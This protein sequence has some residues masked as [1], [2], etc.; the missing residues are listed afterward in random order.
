MIE[1]LGTLRTDGS[2]KGRFENEAFTLF[3]IG[4]FGPES[5]V[6]GQNGATVQKV[7]NWWPEKVQKLDIDMREP[8]TYL[9]RLHWVDERTWQGT[10]LVDG[11]VVSTMDLPPLGPLEVHIWGD[12]YWIKTA[13]NGAPQ[14]NFQIGDTKWIHFDEISVWVES[15]QQSE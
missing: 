15:A 1:P 3:G 14:I 8:H 7:I 2:F 10:T 4:F 11:K 6:S 5:N 12:N 13:F 9:L